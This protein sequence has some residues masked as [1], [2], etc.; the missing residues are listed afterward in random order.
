ML[1][2]AS[3]ATRRRVATVA[4][5][6]LLGMFGGDAAAQ[7]PVNNLLTTV[8]TT[9]QTGGADYAYIL[10]GSP[11]AQLLA[12]KRFAVFGKPGVPT[13]AATFTQRGMIFQR[14]DTASINTLL[15]QSVALGED[16]VT[17]GNTLDALLSNKFN[18]A[19]LSLPELVLTAFQAS[20]TDPSIAQTLGLMVHLKPG[21][22]L[23]AGQ[24]FSE[25][26]AGVTT[27]ELRE[28]DPATG[29]PGD[30]VGRVTITP[31][32]PLVL[33]APGPPY[34][35]TTNDA[36]DH[37]R[38]RLRWGTPPE[39]RR[40][41]MLGFG[42]NI[43]RVAAADA[44][45]AGYDVTP[46]TIAQLHTDPRIKMANKSP[47]MTGKDFTTGPEPGG[48]GDPADGS[49]YF[50]SDSNGRSRGS[51]HFTNSPPAG[52][53]VPP[54]N[55]G[56]QFY[57]FV[58]AR[59]VLGRDGFASPGGIAE[60]C[61]RQPPQAPAGVRVQNNFQVLGSGGSQTNQQRLLVSWQQNINTNDQVTEYWVYRW[62]NPAMALTND[63]VP[64]TNLVG[65]VPQM[66]GTNTGFF[67]DNGP[68]SPTTPGPSNYWYTVR[69][70]SQA[71]CDPLL[72]PHSTPAWAVLRVRYA[73]AAPT[74]SVAGSCGLPTVVFLTANSLT[75]A[76]PASLAYW[77]YRFTCQR[78]D[79]GVAWVQFYATN[80]DGSVTVVGPT[81]FPPGGSAVSANFSPLA[82][83][84][85]GL[86]GVG[87]VVGTYYGQVSPVTAGG[88][89]APP[90][91]NQLF[92]AVFQAADL[93]LTALQPNDPIAATL[94][95]QNGYCSE[96]SDVQSYPDG[97]V[98][99]QIGYSTTNSPPLLIQAQTNPPGFGPPNWFNIGVITPD[100]N[101]YYWIS[102]PACLLG[103]LPQFQG[104]PVIFP[105]GGDCAEHTTTAGDGP[106]AP[107]Q[108]TFMLTPGTH[109]YRLYR[110]TDGGPFSLIAQG[111]AVYDPTDPTRAVAQLDNA[112]P[113]GAAQL[114]YY[115][116][117][118]DENGNGSP[119]ALIG[120]KEAKPPKPPRPVLAQPQPAGDTNNPQVALNWF[121]PPSGVDRFQIL[122]AR[123][124][125]GPVGFGAPGLVQVTNGAPGTSYLGLL[126]NPLVPVQFDAAMFSQPL[127]A[128]LGPGPRFTLSANLPVNTTYLIAVA[129]VDAQGNV[130][131]LSKAWTF[132]WKATNSPLTVP[133]PA[134]PLATL[135]TFDDPFALPGP[136]SRVTA[137]LLR[138]PDGQLDQL[139]PVG[140]R[141]GD[142]SSLLASGTRPPNN[143][144]TTNLASYQ[145]AG[146]KTND[147]VLPPGSADPNT[148]VFARASADPL[149]NGQ[150]L[151]PIVVYRQQAANS[152]FP[153]VSGNVTQVTPLVESLPF[154]ASLDQAAPG[155]FDVVIY[156]RLVGAG[157][158]TTPT[159]DGYFLYL[160]DQQP[161]ILGASYIYTVVRINDKREISEVIPAGTVTIPASGN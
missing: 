20:A 105:G 29:L 95:D 52:Y 61:R 19:G 140:I 81:Y 155:F 135:T 40:V 133:W 76:A 77:N 26:M 161:V 104:C 4:L 151:L 34:Q 58:T 144:G 119:I 124:G 67:L 120:C 71:A 150:S 132:T 146:I 152:A 100:T 3:F 38:V 93:L 153:Q 51:A 84:T 108:I 109:E 126:N 5:A 129:A 9:I 89:A 35:V 47:V 2:L 98:R 97:T 134:R 15:N 63:S 103:P 31:G 42:Y 7:I 130:G 85:G 90:V 8:G 74:G 14:N 128:G 66:P 112:M 160:R 92:E 141:I 145:V 50:F 6:A 94:I 68:D 16:L 41:S 18:V 147:F 96:A 32:N 28:V 143:I 44:A 48:A 139:Y 111:S 65:V 30:V 13:N 136:G 69:A 10:V 79:P 24:A 39:L 57:Y 60:A 115:V 156:D 56:D 83:G 114:C 33:P 123:V 59:D 53:L 23:C 113:P 62:P 106:S 101:G 80:Q 118:L 78:R 121:C 157:H 149:R 45:A 73:P 46:P 154:S 137:E 25:P 17:L 55:D 102:Y 22:T 159:G 158:E 37:L 142:M 11:Q 99:L 1:A 125:S 86:Q 64:L 107:V 127:G 88:F 91:G 36:L 54:F 87:C 110:T 82:I 21:L 70:V 49:T 75:N 131:D 122:V 12:G 27:Y 43:W 72:S 138:G 116:Q 148:F 117:L